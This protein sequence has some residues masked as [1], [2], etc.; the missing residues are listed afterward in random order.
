MPARA[1]PDAPA[2]PLGTAEGTSRTKGLTGRTRDGMGLPALRRHRADRYVKNVDCA[3]LAAA[4]AN[5]LEATL[6]ETVRLEVDGPSISTVGPDGWYGG[7]VRSACDALGARPQ[8]RASS[9]VRRDGAESDSAP[10]YSLPEVNA[11]LSPPMPALPASA[12]ARG[13]RNAK[14]IEV[15]M[16]RRKPS[17]TSIGEWPREE[18]NLRARIRSP[19][20]YPLSYGALEAEY[21]GREG[22]L[23]P[24]SPLRLGRSDT[25]ESYAA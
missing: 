25:D 2:H 22:G 13:N 4:I 3:R 1:R 11:E 16:A 21:P 8:Q 9:R 5:R 18:S 14:P 20:L 7:Y 10:R 19:S 23:S 15:I 24:P 6:P 17:R 12:H